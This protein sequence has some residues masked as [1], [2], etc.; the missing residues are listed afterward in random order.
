MNTI[1]QLFPLAL[2]FAALT[3]GAAGKPLAVKAKEAPPAPVS[4]AASPI[5]F[6]ADGKPHGPTLTVNP[7]GA[8]YTMTGEAKATAPGVYT[9]TVAGTGKF[10]GSMTCKWRIDNAPTGASPYPPRHD[11]SPP[12]DPKKQRPK[13]APSQP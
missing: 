4:F 13:P 5:R 7:Q 9:F 1:R 3:L 6:I 12:I 11:K 2:M 8:T 10:T